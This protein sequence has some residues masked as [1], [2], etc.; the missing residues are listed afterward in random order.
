M[1]EIKTFS[2][3]VRYDRFTRQSWT[4]KDLRLSFVNARD[5]RGHGLTALRIA[6]QELNAELSKLKQYLKQVEG[7][8]RPNYKQDVARIKQRRSFLV[9]LRTSLSIALQKERD[10]VQK[11]QDRAFVACL[12]QACQETLPPQQYESILK[13]ALAKQ[14][15]RSSLP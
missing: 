7:A 9:Y 8:K 3:P 6:D 15:K 10:K 14:A 1:V 4:S 11:E 5:F 12:K 2:P 13:L